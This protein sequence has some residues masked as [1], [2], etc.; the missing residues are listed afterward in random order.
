M[1]LRDVDAA[2][3]KDGCFGGRCS[4]AILHRSRPGHWTLFSEFAKPLGKL[5]A[6]SDPVELLGAGL[7]VNTGGV[8]P[9]DE[10]VPVIRFEI[11]AYV[12]NGALGLLLVF[13][14]S[15]TAGGAL[16][17]LDA[18]RTQAVQWRRMGGRIR[19][20]RRKDGRRRARAAAPHPRQAVLVPGHESRLAAGRRSRG[21]GIRLAER[22]AE[23]AKAQTEPPTRSANETVLGFLAA[24]AQRRSGESGQVDK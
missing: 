19:R 2:G 9:V 1:S 22:R 14:V 5:M 18:G 4:G 10:P 16:A 6:T 11:G 13:S 20:R 7:Q 23:L 3:P 15:A 21:D 12:H 8:Y 17:G 24:A